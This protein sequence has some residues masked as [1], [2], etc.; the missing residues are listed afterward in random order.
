MLI[1]EGN[2]ITKWCP[3]RRVSN[4]EVG[5][6]YNANHVGEDYMDSEVSW[7]IGEYCMMWR[8]ASE[9]DSTYHGYCGLA[10]KPVDRVG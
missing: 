3:M 7:C 1:K 5:D 2:A 9:D 8:W 10:G 4:K 6:G